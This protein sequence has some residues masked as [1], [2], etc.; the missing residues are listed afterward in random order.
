MFHE[1]NSDKIV[2]NIAI[3]HEAESLIVFSTVEQS[4]DLV[5]MQKAAHFFLFFKRLT[6][7]KGLAV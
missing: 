6:Y 7:I 4:K 2:K 3:F 1:G 5:T